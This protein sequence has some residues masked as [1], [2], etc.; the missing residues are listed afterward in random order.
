MLTLFW[1]CLVGGFALTLLLFLFGD[2]LEGLMDALDALDGF[3]DPLSLVGGVSVFGGSGILL[4]EL[5]GLS[6]TGTLVAAIVFGVLAVL[7]IHFAYVR[8]LKRGEAS[9]GFSVEE[10]R[11]RLGE[12]ITAIPPVGFGEVLIPMGGGGNT[13][14]QAASFEGTSIPGGARIVVVDVRDGDLL[15]APFEDEPVALPEVTAPESAS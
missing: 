7:A 4:T 2:V 14:R 6:E 8:P 15:V 12:V 13:F 1:A 5:T 9:T 11:G 3:I 10:Y